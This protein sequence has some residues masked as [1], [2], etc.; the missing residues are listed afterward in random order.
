[1]DM[2]RLA[3]RCQVTLESFYYKFL[4][5]LKS[6]QD[7]LP[8]EP[9]TRY[10]KNKSKEFDQKRGEVLVGAFLPPN[11]NTTISVFNISGMNEKSIWNMGRLWTVINP[12]PRP[13]GENSIKARADIKTSIIIDIEELNAKSVP[14]P[15][16][17]HVDLTNWPSD[18]SHKN[19]IAL[20]IARKSIF[21][22][23]PR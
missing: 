16:P 10:L 11:N 17:R 12:W 4:T 6:P 1:M 5:L 8:E 14:S 7:P 21:K 13:S 15:N 9:L 22:P 19:L 18:E 2:K 20:Q 23:A 3:D